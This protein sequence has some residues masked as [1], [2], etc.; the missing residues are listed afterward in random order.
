[1]VQE[2]G[3]GGARPDRAHVVPGVPGERD[4]PFIEVPGLGPAFLPEIGLAL[5][6][7]R[8]GLAA[9]VALLVE[10]PLGKREMRQAGLHLSFF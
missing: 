2:D 5:V 4:R 1:M 9:P 7:E 8:L 10:H 6:M 3:E